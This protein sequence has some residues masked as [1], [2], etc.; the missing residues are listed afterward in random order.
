MRLLML[1]DLNV[2]YWC[3]K[4]LAVTS[5]TSTL[6]QFSLDTTSL[7]SLG[8]FA[9]VLTELQYERSRLHQIEDNCNW[10]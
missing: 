2:T 1:L 6:I 4:Q 5:L 9:G 3:Q 10:R 7:G 8:K